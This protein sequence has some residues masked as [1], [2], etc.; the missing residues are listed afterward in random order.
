MY[1][2]F[3]D[4][5]TAILYIDANND[6]LPKSAC[7]VNDQKSTKHIF[8]FNKRSS[9]DFSIA[10]TQPTICELFLTAQPSLFTSYDVFYVHLLPCPLGFT[11]QNG[12]CD[13]D[14]DLRKYIDECMISDQ[15]VQRISNTYI[16][17]FEEVNL[18]SKYM[19]SRN[20]PTYY[21]LQGT[22]RINLN[23]MHPDVQCQPHRTGLL[24]SQCTEG[25]SVV[26]ASSHCKK[27][28]NVH[29]L[30]LLYFMLTGFVLIFILFFFN[31]TVTSGAM[32]CL[33]FYVNIVR[34]SSSAMHLSDRLLSPLLA[35]IYI[36]NIETYVERYLYDGMDMYAKRFIA[37]AYP[38]Y[39]LVIASS[40]IL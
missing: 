34:L 11:L 31:L 10:S 35:Y 20:C 28:S 37:L 12:I 39:F 22:K 9:V 26:F 14:P 27:C 6:N 25:Y 3:N 36:V 32:N 38:L 40:L 13:C 5:E 23:H 4:K 21:C 7:I 19:V 15:T 18:T 29:L 17:G 8:H 1:S 24:C 33:I 30:N 2:C 16:M